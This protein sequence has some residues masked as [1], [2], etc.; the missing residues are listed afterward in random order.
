[1]IKNIIFD[2]DGVICESINIKSDAFYEMYL[3]YGKEIAQKVKEHHIQNG[4]MSRFDKFRYYEQEFIGKDLSEEKMKKLSDEFS[5]RVKQ[6]VI[7]APFVEGVFEFLKDYSQNYNCFIVS[8]TPIDEIR[9]IAEKKNISNYFRGIFGSPK[10]KIE[11]GKYILE[12]YKLKA[13]ETLFIGDAKSDYIAAKANSMDFLL[14]NTDESSSLFRNNNL[15][16]IEN[17][18]DFYLLLEDYKK[19]KSAP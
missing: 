19:Q 14:R 5:K 12:T 7:A 8:A 9:E 16:S 10:N 11:W 4:G 2:F 17:F 15:T 6:K 3:P 18:K 13:D 1:M